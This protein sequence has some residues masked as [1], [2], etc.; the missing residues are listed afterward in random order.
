MVEHPW[1]KDIELPD[2]EKVECTNVQQAMF[3]VRGGHLIE[4]KYLEQMTNKLILIGQ[5]G[6]PRLISYQDLLRESGGQEGMCK[7]LRDYLKGLEIEKFDN[8]MEMIEEE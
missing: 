3:F 2:I 6:D 8:L 4:N 5:G 1:L 7:L